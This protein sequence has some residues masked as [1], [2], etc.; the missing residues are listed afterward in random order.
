MGHMAKKKGSANYLHFI[1]I[2]ATVFQTKIFTWSPR[3][4]QKISL[5][6]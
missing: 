5:L 2:H 6:I 3:N 4:V 1:I